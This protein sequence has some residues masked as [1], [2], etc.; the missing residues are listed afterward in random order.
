MNKYALLLA[1]L[2]F[3]MQASEQQTTRDRVEFGNEGERIVVRTSQWP[4]FKKGLV[5]VEQRLWVDSDG[6]L[7]YDYRKQS[8]VTQRYHRQF[9]AED[10]MIPAW[11][12]DATFSDNSAGWHCSN[13]MEQESRATIPIEDSATWTRPRSVDYVFS[14]APSG[15]AQA[16]VNFRSSGSVRFESSQTGS[17]QASASV[18]GRCR[19]D[20]SQYYGSAFSGYHEASVTC[21]VYEPRF[22]STRM[23][24]C[25]PRQCGHA[26]GTISVR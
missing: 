15:T 12:G 17:I 19:T 9:C 11:N 8:G 3:S 10:G 25:V 24:G 18:D 13:S 22:V 4:D 7:H 23:E 2:P 21:I 5:D 26:N 16:G 14:T 20:F 1:T 6:I